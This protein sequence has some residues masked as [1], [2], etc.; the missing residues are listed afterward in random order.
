MKTSIFKNSRKKGDETKNNFKQITFVLTLLLLMMGK[1]GL[2]QTATYTIASTS[3]V[4]TSGTAPSGSSATFSNTYTTKEQLT[5]GKVATL[6]LSGYAGYKITSIVLNMK[7]NASTGAGEMKVVAGSTTIFSIP[8]ATAFNNASWYGAWSSTY[9]NLTKTP[10]AYDITTGQ[11]V[12]FTITCSTNSL[13][14]T[15]YTITYEPVSTTPTITPSVASLS[16][17]SYTQGSGPSARQMFTISGANLTG[18]GNITVNGSTNYEVSTDGTTFGATA[19]Y[20]F[21]GGV[22]TGQ[23][24]T[25]YVRLKAGLTSASSPYNNELIAISG[26]SATTINVTCSGTVTPAAGPTLTTSTASLSGFT[27]AVG[28]GPSTEQSFT[29]SGANLTGFTSNITVSAPTNYEVSLTAGS[30]FGASVNVPYTTA[31]LA[32]T[33]I[34][35]RL[36]SGLTATTYTGNITIAG[37]GDADGASVAL[38]GSVTTSGSSNVFISEFAGAGYLNDFNDEYIELTNNGSASQDLTGWSLLYYNATT[39]EATINLTGSIAQNSAYLIAVRSTA[40]TINGVTPN[41]AGAFASMNSTGY[42]VLKNA[43]STIVDQA[44]GSADKFSDSKNYEFTN[45]VGDNLPTNNWTDLGTGNG[46]PGVVNCATTTPTITTS[47][48]SLSGFTYPLGF[49]PSISQSFNLSGLLLTG[50]TSNI[51]ITGTT[52]YEVSTDNTTFGSS[53]TVEYTSA[54]LASTPIY[55]R[56]KAG[57]SVN[58]YNSETITISGGGDADGATVTCSGEVTPLDVTAPTVSTYSP[59]DNAT[60]VAISSNLVLTFNENVQKGTG[61]IYIKKVSDNSIVQTIDVTNAVVGIS[62]AV[63]T[64]NPPSDLVISTDY[65][66]MIDAGAIKDLANNNFAGIS[67]TTTWNFTTAGLTYCTSNGN[68]SYQTSVT[69]VTL[70]TINNTTAKPAAYNDYTS[71]STSLQQNESYNLSVSVNTAGSF[72]LHTFAWIDWNIDGDFADAGESFD[73]GVATN[74]ASG[75]T[76]LSPLSITVPITATV[77]TTRMR[78]STRYSSDPTTCGT[79]FDGEVED[80]SIVVVAAGPTF[81]LSSLPTFENVCINTTAGPESFTITGTNLTTANVT[82]AALSGFTYSTTSGG[83]YTSTLTLT[84]SGGNLS[85]Q[86]FVKFSPTLVQSYDGNIVVS[87]GGATSKNCAASGSGVNYA[88]TITSPTSASVTTTTALLGGNI[89]DLGCSNVTKRGIFWSTTSDFADGTGTEVS[90]TA[91][92]PYSTG[93]FTVNV[94]GLSASTVYYFKAFTENSI[95][96]VYT[97]Q[98]TFSTAC[99]AITSL[100]WNEGFESLASVGTNVFPPCWYKENGDWQSADA[101]TNS[102]NDPRTGSKYITNTHSATNEY[103]WTPGFTL[104]AGISYDFSFWYVGDGNAGWTG[105]VFYNTNQQSTGATQLGSAFIT[106]STTSVDTYGEVVSTFT[107]SSTGTYYFAIRVNANL[108]PWHIGY[109][110]FQLK[111]SVIEPEPTNH[112]TAFTCGTTTASSIPLTWSDATGT[113]TPH[114]YLVKW[115]SVGYGSIVSPIDGTATANGSDALNINSAV[116]AANITGL[117]ANTVYY[118]KIFP[119]TNSGVNI[120]YKVDGTMPTTSCNTQVDASSCTAPTT[121]SSAILF[122]NIVGAGMTLNWTSGNGNNRIIIATIGSEVPFTPVTGTT[123]TANSAFGSGANLGNGQYCIYNGS[124]NTM[125]VTGLTPNTLYT[126]AI[127]EYNC[128]PGIEVYGV[129]SASASQGTNDYVSTSA[130]SGSPFCVSNSNNAAI[131]VPFT[132]QN[133]ANYTSGTAIFTAQLSDRNGSFNNPIDIGTITSNASGSQTISATLPAGIL[134]GTNYKIRVNSATPNITGSGTQVGFTIINSPDN[135]IL[136]APLEQ[137]T[138]VSI[139]WSAPIGCYDDYMV[140]VSTASIAATPTGDGSAYTANTVYGSGTPFDG[141]F[142]VQKGASTSE[143]ITGLTDGTTYYVRVYTRWGTDWSIGSEITIN[144]N[145]ATVLN[146]GDLAILAVNT[147]QAG[148]D[149]ISFVPFKSIITSTTIDFTDNGYERLYAGKW[150]NSEGTLRLTRIGSTLPAGSVITFVGISSSATPNL[151]TDFNV[152]VNGANDNVNWNI[153]SLN[154]SGPFDLN[155]N[156]QIWIMQHGTWAI[157]SLH[158]AT[159]S[160]SALYGWTSIGWETAPGYNS[161]IGSTIPAGAVCAV[162]NVAGKTNED[163][164]KYTGPITPASK[165]EWI[166]RI[167]EPS[168]WTDYADNTAFD[169]GLPKYKTVGATLNVLSGN[170][171]VPGKWAGYSSTSWCDCANWRSLTVPTATDNVEIPAN[172]IR[173]VELSDHADSLAICKNLIVHGGTIFGKDARGKKITVNGDLIINGGTIDFAGTSDADGQIIVYGSFIDSTGGTGFIHGKSLV[174]FAGG[175]SQSLK[176]L[177]GTGQSFYHLQVNKSGGAVNM[178]ND[179]QVTDSMTFTAG[180]INASTYTVTLGQS[181]INKGILMHTSG[182]VNGKLRRWFDGT[183]SGSQTGLFPVGTA[184]YY[185]PITIEY[186]SAAASGGHLTTNFVS[187]PMG[188]AGLTILAVNSGGFGMDIEQSSNDGYWKVDN[189]AGKLTDGQY[190][191]TATL[192]GANGISNVSRLTLIK[193]VGAGNWLAPGTHVAAS[194]TTS[195]PTVSRTGLAGYSNFGLGSGSGNSLPV[196]FVAFDALCNDLGVELLWTTATESNNSHFII[197]RSLDGFSWN[198]IAQIAGAGNSSSLINYKY[199]DKGVDVNYYYRLT[200]VDYNGNSVVYDPIVTNCV[201]S[202]DVLISVYPNPF[203]DIL[204][205]HIS[206]EEQ[207]LTVSLMDAT[208]KLVMENQVVITGTFDLN[209]ST[210]APGIYALKVLGNETNQV[211]KVVKR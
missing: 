76:S 142:V 167:N 161:T 31:T 33:T 116:Q 13:Y 62:G 60:G 128:T 168:N 22:I 122:S 166:G 117:T 164:V 143:T 169:N 173:D 55:V 187:S 120:N 148:G 174:T 136:N 113:T 115:S 123:Y 69:N 193:R 16:G 59:A 38:S 190:T 11:D 84:P 2:G 85:Q 36:V 92:A 159:Y 79:G 202:N 110:D 186:T 126:F 196:E 197:E 8:S 71:T 75:T 82:V 130:I 80:Y 74:T 129:T 56:L 32:S 133:S 67:V 172:F 127:F 21:A 50:F 20:P 160:G 114:G 90:T 170:L 140:V 12:V 124:G 48:A 9:V 145:T 155:E 68:T 151:G 189:E 111:S 150:A 106:S 188:T 41:L 205:I 204:T 119:Y 135:V 184:S 141:G 118:F 28:S 52:N 70:N 45:C 179:I 51:T 180:K 72:T 195:A 211:F 125:A 121:A 18:S 58:T 64:I 100:P 25:V 77:G 149:E 78:V 10:S 61:N 39:L 65:Y 107:P 104:T 1:I 207:Q 7:S 5:A 93:A 157:G 175:N 181:T 86:V 57:L 63:V 139:S 95:G 208:G 83:T 34:Y 47:V 199:N 46:T 6:T 66:V 162:T 131:S 203:N 15:S 96:R 88:P 182:Y 198:R 171:D 146:Y 30:G 54:T 27:Y 194:G 109:D 134:S 112:A 152:F 14:I 44:G 49:G 4:T 132:Y 43:S 178:Y 23:P 29:L 105:E 153:S 42:V 17:F 200:Q 37:G 176:M 210:L 81:T 177:H 206:G 99:T 191:F 98:G 40:G 163:K 87:G 103:I 91:G 201:K 108:T 185:R 183:N 165:I 73:L 24:K 3:S 192:N 209:T 144:P 35:V 154:G 89:T 138:Q 26:G 156:D 158:N 53:I 97:S 102:Y 147:D 137:S 101:S 19:L 94:S